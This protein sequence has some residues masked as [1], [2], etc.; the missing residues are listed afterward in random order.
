MNHNFVG[1]ILPFTG[2]DINMFTRKPKSYGMFKKNEIHDKQIEILNFVCDV[3]ISVIKQVAAL[4][5]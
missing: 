1:N 2:H 4:V 5:W 3:L